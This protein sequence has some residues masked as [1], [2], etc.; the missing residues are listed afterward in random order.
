MSK[1]NIKQRVKELLRQDI[2]LAD[3]DNKL[4]ICYYR[5]HSNENSFLRW[6]PDNMKLC[7]TITRCRRI[8]EAECPELRGKGYNK[9]HNILEPE[10]R[11]KVLSGEIYLVIKS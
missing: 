11:E 6:F 7:N 4:I 8:I 2:S 10:F 9:R 1:T 5:T 3:N